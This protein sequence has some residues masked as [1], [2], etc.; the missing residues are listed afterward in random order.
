M[1]QPLSV[2]EELQ[3]AYAIVAG[4]WAEHRNSTIA[5]WIRR[6]WFWR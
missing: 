5:I 3:A 6:C 2:L 1:E 4:R